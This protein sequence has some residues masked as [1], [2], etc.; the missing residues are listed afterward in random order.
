MKVLVEEF[1]EPV[2]AVVRR[3]VAAINQRVGAIY[4]VGVGLE[5]GQPRNVR[6]VLPKRGAR[7]SHSGRKLT[8]IPMMQIADRRSQ[9]HNVSWCKAA[10]EN[11]LSHRNTPEAERTTSFSQLLAP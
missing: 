7:C 4:R 6:V 1:N 8:W 2:K 3:L 5:I 10:L 9:H 11:Q